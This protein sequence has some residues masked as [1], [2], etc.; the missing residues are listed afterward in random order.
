MTERMTKL[1]ED[2]RIAATF[3]SLYP[4]CI[5]R[6]PNVCLT[7]AQRRR[8]WANIKPTWGDRPVLSGN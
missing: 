8:R 1:V 3:T 4:I 7:L 2:T 6:E 5:R